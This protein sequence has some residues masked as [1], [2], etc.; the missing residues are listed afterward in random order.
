MVNETEFSYRPKQQLRFLDVRPEDPVPTL[1]DEDPSTSH[2]SVLLEATG[3]ALP[4]CL[5][6]ATSTP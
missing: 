2:V 3:R 5:R 4:A 1:A 6:P